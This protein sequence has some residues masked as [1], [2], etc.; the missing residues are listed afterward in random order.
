M[1]ETQFLDTS[2]FSQLAGGPQLLTVLLAG[3]LS[4]LTPCVYPLIPITL[5]LF[6]ATSE[7]SRLR[8]F[9]LA[10]VYVLGISCTYTALGIFCA[11]TG[12]VF[13]AF[14]GNPWVVA[15]LCLFMI[16]LALYSLDCFQVSWIF[17]LQTWASRVQGTGLRGAFLMGMFSGLVAAPCVGPVLSAVLLLA[18]QSKDYLWGG[19]LLFV[20]SI[21]LGFIFVLLGTFSS[22]LT[23]LPR[24]GSWMY[25]VKFIT[26]AA[27]FLVCVLL[28]APL[29]SKHVNLELTSLGN[30]WA[31]FALACIALYLGYLSFKRGL[32]KL[33]IAAALL[34]AFSG[35]ALLHLPPQDSQLS[36]GSELEAG[37]SQ[38]ASRKQV[39]MLDL[40]AEWCAACKEF[41]KITFQDAQV[42]AQLKEFALVRLDFTIP[43][44]HSDQVTQRFSVA[45][46]PTI[47]FLDPQGREIPGSRITGFKPAAEFLQHLI[48]VSTSINQ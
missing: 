15:A 45:G 2:A 8:S 33:K 23:R 10:S 19:V 22:L 16:L 14:L 38:A 44:E 20:Y 32:L 48:K 28:L 4:S 17:K 36:W 35:F 5:A 27:L 3:F 41:D 30:P 31:S 21:G 24:S 26:A 40:F 42:V 29:L 47:L 34:L 25:A 12:S 9:F 37:I 6:G 18:A 43:D 11:A 46:L 7:N 39:L 13:G 1:D